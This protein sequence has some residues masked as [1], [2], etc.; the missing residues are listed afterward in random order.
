[1]FMDM[2][3]SEAEKQ[4]EQRGPNSRRINHH[5]RMRRKNRL[6]NRAPMVPTPRFV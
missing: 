6:N 4:T 5:Q 2:M 3:I 1:M